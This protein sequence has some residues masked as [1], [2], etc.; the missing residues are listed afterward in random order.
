MK[1]KLDMHGLPSIGA[2]RGGRGDKQ[3]L[4]SFADVV[5]G[6]KSSSQV[7][8]NSDNSNSNSMIDHNNPDLT[9]LD[10]LIMVTGHAVMRISNI[11]DAASDDNAWWL[12]SYQQDQDFPRIIT[13]H[14]Q[15]G[16][17]LALTDPSALLIFSGGRYITYVNVGLL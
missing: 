4:K 10:H 3:S 11:K 17:S 2:L 6:Q 8:R 1:G 14:V 13:S 16:V 9:P 5:G 7:L 12:L 15:T